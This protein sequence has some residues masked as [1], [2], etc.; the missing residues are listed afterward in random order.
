MVDLVFFL[1]QSMEF[2]PME[3]QEAIKVDLEHF[4]E[5]VDASVKCFEEVVQVES[6]EEMEKELQNTSST[7][8]DIELGRSPP[9]DGK[10]CEKIV[11]SLLQHSREVMERLDENVGADVKDQLVLCLASI[12]F[13]IE[14]IMREIKETEK[15]I[16]ELIQSENPCN[17]NLYDL[18]C[19]VKVP[20]VLSEATPR[21]A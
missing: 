19:R 17:I 16:L 11:A 1:A 20:S 14:G 10:E 5:M 2:L 6:L 4:K 13:C 18:F 15:G 12:G 8:Y 21:C 3:V 9:R 7:S